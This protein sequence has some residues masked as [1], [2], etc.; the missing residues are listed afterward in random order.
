MNRD[1]VDRHEFCRQKAAPTGSSLY[2]SILYQHPDDKHLLC[3]LHAFHNALV[4]IISESSDPGVAHIKFAWWQEELQRLANGQPRHPVTQAM[5][6]MALSHETIISLGQIVEHYDRHIDLKQPA[7]Y[8]QLIDFLQQG[9]GL[10]WQILASTIGYQHPDTPAIMADLG[11]QFGYFNILQEQP[12]HLHHQRHYLPLDETQEITDKTSLYDLQLDRLEKELL[13]LA[14][15]I[16]RTD[17]GKQRHALV[18][19]RITAL[20]CRESRR[21]GSHLLHQRVS[22]TPVRKLWIAWYCKWLYR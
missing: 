1:S 5:A 10:Y 6:E 11:T 19:A 14:G 15:L 20:T 13:R 3:I 16:A 12:W 2:Y 22:L 18:L 8:R 21:A 4:E 7:N 17:R 9:P